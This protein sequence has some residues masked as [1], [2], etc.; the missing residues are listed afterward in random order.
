MIVWGNPSGGDWNTGANWQGG[1]KPG[2]AD[3]AVI[4][5]AVANPITHS[6]N[7]TDQVNSLSV[8]AQAPVSLGTGTLKI[9]GTLAS[10]GS[11][12]IAGGTLQNA[13]VMA[14][15]TITAANKQ[16]HHERRDARRH[17]RHGQ[18]LSRRR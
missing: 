3:D 14:G 5:I 7:I 13:T 16:Q 6:Q 1:V 9:A 11:F 17:S 15:T 10:N 4:N 2:P 18:R 12:T 8:T